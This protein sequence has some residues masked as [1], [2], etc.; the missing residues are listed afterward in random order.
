M[1]TVYRLNTSFALPTQLTNQRQLCVCF[2]SK[3]S[4]SK[5]ADKP[6]VYS[7]LLQ[8]L[9]YKS[10][11]Q[12]IYISPRVG[13]IKEFVYNF[14]LEHPVSLSQRKNLL[15]KTLILA[16]IKWKNGTL[17]FSQIF[18]KPRFWAHACGFIFENWSSVPL[19]KGC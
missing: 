6:D 12:G 17:N 1:V 11:W 2:D 3:V 10:F 19:I 14:F 15:T 13:W 8:I 7:L 18:N 4:C 5:L 9:W 16:Q